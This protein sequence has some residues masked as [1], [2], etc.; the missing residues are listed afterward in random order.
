MINTTY[1]LVIVGTV[2]VVALGL[3]LGFGLSGSSGSN[4][5]QP[6]QVDQLLFD[7]EGEEIAWSDGDALVDGLGAVEV[8]PTPFRT[9]SRLIQIVTYSF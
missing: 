2:V 8:L 9:E 7:W 4:D 5:N 6:G 1:I 3:G